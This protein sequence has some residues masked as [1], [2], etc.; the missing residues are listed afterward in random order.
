MT[1]HELWSNLASR[2][3]SGYLCRGIVFVFILLMDHRVNIGCY[4]VSLLVI[5]SSL[6]LL[7]VD[8]C[9]SFDGNHYSSRTSVYVGAKSHSTL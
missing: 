8:R 4:H 1:I 2:E 7:L 3:E 6:Y 9:Y 5:L